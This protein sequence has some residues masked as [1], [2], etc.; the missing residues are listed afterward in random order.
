MK[1]C[2]KCNQ[3]KELSEFYRAFVCKSCKKIYDALHYQKNQE[4]IKERDK[5]YRQRNEDKLRVYYQTNKERTKKHQKEYRQNNPEKVKARHKKYDQKNRGKINAKNAKRYACK[6]QATPKSLTKEQL[7]EIETFYVEAA[8][9][10][11]E[12]GISHHVDHILPLQGEG[13]TGFHVPWN[14]QILTGLENSKKNN[15]FDGTYENESWR[16]I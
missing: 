6:L 7:F 14:L 2:S 16:L 15:S 5:K 10:T 9:L 1:K 3:N 11:K 8:R 12:T 4:E 13:I